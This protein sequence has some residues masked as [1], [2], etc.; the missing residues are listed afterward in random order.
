MA[1]SITGISTVIETGQ[2]GGN[3]TF[4]TPSGTPTTGD[5]LVA[6][7]G[8]RSN[9]G[10]TPNSAVWN[11]VATQQLS[12]DTDATSGIASGGMWYTVL[13]SGTDP[14]FL[15]NRTGGNV[16]QGICVRYRGVDT[17]SP[18]NT[19]NAGTLGAVGEPSLAQLTSIPANNLLVA[20]VSSGDATLCT[21]FDAVTDPSV[22]SST[23]DTTT[24]PVVGTWT[25]RADSST[26]TGADHGLS[27]ADGVKTSLG[28]TGTF[29]ANAVTTSRSVFIV[30]AFTMGAVVINNRLR[31]FITNA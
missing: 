10:F 1:W 12:G 5:L 19:G 9:A 26:G 2:T 16:A 8:M 15:F 14:D 27:I 20:M 11:L 28:N 24:A 7:M 4:N 22:V 21:A 13:T 6:C 30:A 23:I 25:H 29:S 17:G 18:Y 3:L 31:M